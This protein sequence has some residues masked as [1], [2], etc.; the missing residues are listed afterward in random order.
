[1]VLNASCLYFPFPYRKYFYEKQYNRAACVAG[2]T[3]GALTSAVCR[4]NQSDI[5][6]IL[7]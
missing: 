1:M 4:P 7:T 5:Q 6:S 3:R 2:H